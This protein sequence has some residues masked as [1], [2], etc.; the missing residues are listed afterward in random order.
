A[1]TL[2][3]GAPT[4]RKGSRLSMPPGVTPFMASPRRPVPWTKSSP[5]GNPKPKFCVRRNFA[6][7]T[8]V[9]I[10]SSTPLAE[11]RAF[12]TLGRGIE[13]DLAGLLSKHGV[14]PLPSFFKPA[15]VREGRARAL[16]GG[17]WNQ[18]RELALGNRVNYV[19]VGASE[20]SYVASD[21]FGGF[22]T[23]NLQLQL[24]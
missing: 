7:T 11:N 12:G 22:L 1:R 5:Y 21:Q 13:A 20:A 15:F 18:A 4:P 2:T 17:D 8:P 10:P 3:N 14:E 23:A 24:K 6:L 16:F 19:V 9:N